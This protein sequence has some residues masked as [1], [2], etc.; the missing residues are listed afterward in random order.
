[1]LDCLMG[2]QEFNTWYE[3]SF[4]RFINEKGGRV[5][6]VLTEGKYWAEIDFEEDLN[7]VRNEL[8]KTC[9]T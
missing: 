4:L 2:E 8:K 1:M 3:S 5:T 9:G 6:Y 7:L